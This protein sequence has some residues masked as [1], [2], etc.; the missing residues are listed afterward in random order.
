MAEPISIHRPCQQCH[1]AVV[2]VELVNG[3]TRQF[4]CGPCFREALADLVIHNE[5][6]CFR[7]RLELPIHVVEV[8]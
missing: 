3:E 4:L 6:V 8:E 1:A 7:S 5:R 2:E